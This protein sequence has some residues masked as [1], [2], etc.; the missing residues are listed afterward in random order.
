MGKRHRLSRVIL[1]AIALG[2]AT[3][4][5]GAASSSGGFDQRVLA[6]HNQER[7]ALGLAPLRWDAGLAAD[8]QRWADHLA[9]TQR[10]EHAP[11]SRGEPQGEN[12]WAGTR[13]YFSPEAMVNAWIR[14]KRYFRPGRFPNNSTTGDVED[15][16]HYTQLVWR[17]TGEVG[18]ARAANQGD[19][20]LVCRYT[21]AGNYVGERPF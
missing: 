4:L 19:D 3:L 17:E 12:L 10:F 14:E 6:A 18:C 2:A 8:A 1:G 5:S 20:F 15:V 16:G 21:Q 7:A 13:G 9:A 11:D